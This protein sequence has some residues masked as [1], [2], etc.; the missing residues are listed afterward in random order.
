[1]AQLSL[2]GRQDLGEER[3][4]EAHGLIVQQDNVKLC[5]V[6]L[7]A[8]LDVVVEE[9]DSE[10]N[11]GILHSSRHVNITQRVSQDDH[12]P[13]LTALLAGSLPDTLG[14]VIHVDQVTL[15]S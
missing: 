5:L 1:M 3:V 12:V 6:G 13:P 14:L 10:D 9:A 8:G 11:T 2:G 15:L 4:G 7:Q